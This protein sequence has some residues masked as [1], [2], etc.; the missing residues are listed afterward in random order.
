MTGSFRRRGVAA[1]GVAVALCLAA[2]AC[3]STAM[4][5]GDTLTD[6]KQCAPYQQYLGHAGTKVHVY[7]SIGDFEANQLQQALRHFG[8]CTGIDVRYEGSSSFETDVR[9]RVADGQSP[10]LAIFPQP[11]L[12]KDFIAQGKVKPASAATKA[13]AEKGWS[14]D[15]LN[16]GSVD[17]KFYAAPLGASV[18]SLVWYSPKTFA[19]KGYKVP[20]SWDEMIALSD[21]IV[22]DGGKPWCAGIE[23]GDATG[24][25]ATDWMEDVTLRL[26]GPETYDKWVNHQ[27]PFN[28][29]QIAAVTDKV[30]T[31]L[32]NPK[33]V[34]GGFGGVDSIA[35]T[36][37]QTG[38]LPILSGKCAM[39]R[40]AS[41]YAGQWPRG[42]KVAEDGDVFAFYF[43]SIDPAKGKP[44]LVAGEFVAAFADR[45]EVQAVQAFMASGEYATNRAALGGWVTAN[46]LVDM[47]LFT[48]PVDNLSAEI[49]RDDK[50]VARFDGS[51]Q[52]PGSVGAGTFWTGMTA[53][54]KGASTKDTLDSIEASWPKSN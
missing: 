11:G 35:T 23:S 45:P 9:K 42:T 24:W 44:V 4:M 25:P 5:G 15:W 22:A 2:A 26:A 41:F 12:M 54:I 33:Y 40:Q 3:G 52:M 32:K 39:H 8:D 17:G 14:K 13:N 29:P 16:Y 20:Q 48:S 28:D 49:L 7:G 27:I 37:F 34:N 30:G 18:K 50:T 51:D 38:G 21:K 36:S 10:D 43:P 1:A 53:W 19:A 31:I 6:A 46:K 47:K